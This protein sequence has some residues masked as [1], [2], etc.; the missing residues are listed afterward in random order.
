[1]EV[2]SAA[3]AAALGLDGAAAAALG[4]EG[5]A[6]AFALDGPL[7][8]DD[9]EGSPVSRLRSRLPWP[10]TGCCCACDGEGC[11]PEALAWRSGPRRALSCGSGSAREV[12]K[13]PSLLAGDV[14]RS[15]ASSSTGQMAWI[16]LL[17]RSISLRA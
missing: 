8:E 15:A 17:I 9:R 11:C 12:K 5:A 4:L 13:L 2:S 6:A 10:C 7:T 14:S 1:M 16:S 3:A